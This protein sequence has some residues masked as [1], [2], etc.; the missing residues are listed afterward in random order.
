[1][2]MTGQRLIGHLLD[3]MVKC[4]QC[5][6]P[7]E[8]SGQ[9][10]HAVLRYVCAI[11]DEGCTTPDIEAEPFNRLVVRRA[12][13]AFLDPQNTRK[14]RDII[15]DHALQEDNGEMRTLLDLVKGS[16]SSTG[17]TPLNPEGQITLITP[18]GQRTLITLKYPFSADF[19]PADVEPFD[20]NMRVLFA[21]AASQKVEEYSLNPDT[22][23][24]P[25]NLQTTQAIITAL[26]REILVG[27][28]FA[29]IHYRLSVHPGGQAEPGTSEE[30]P[31][32]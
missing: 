14:V 32:R 26:I 12:I 17:E 27:L 22:Y 21:G 20:T 10:Q 1:M 6:A 29:T 3:G 13:H 4:R 24:R 25:S 7:M 19:D 11:K 18:E 5:D 28:D 16:S 2:T 30:V 9:S 15:I 31:I 8:I 23:L